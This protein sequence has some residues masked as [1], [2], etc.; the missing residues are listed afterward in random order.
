[1][2]RF[3]MESAAR[4]ECLVCGRRVTPETGV[5]VRNLALLCHDDAGAALAVGYLF[6]RFGIP[7]IKAKWPAV[8]EAVRKAA[9]RTK[10]R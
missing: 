2:L 1:M 6:K 3:A 7:A 10:A 8:A 9:D 5:R 4:S